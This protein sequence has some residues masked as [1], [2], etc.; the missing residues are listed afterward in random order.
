MELAFETVAHL[1]LR[2]LI[3]SENQLR[4]LDPR[5]SDLFHPGRRTPTTGLGG[6]DASQLASTS[7]IL[8]GWGLL[9]LTHNPLDCVCEMAWLAELIEAEYQDQISLQSA[10]E[11]GRRSTRSLEDTGG[12][13]TTVLS[14]T[15][16]DAS[17]GNS[18]GDT[19]HVRRMSELNLTCAGPPALRGKRLPKTRGLLCP[20]PMV[21][22]IEV[23]LY[24]TE[25]NLAQLTCVAKAQTPPRL[26][27]AFQVENQVNHLSDFSSIIMQM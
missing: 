25:M 17:S 15:G 23:Q 22:G 12:P 27:W 3:L 24:P 5:F 7:W 14:G 11:T 4:R 18:L 2:E 20:A 10:F 26:M 8:S 6:R 9:D 13:A 19:G 21:T 16:S 1:S